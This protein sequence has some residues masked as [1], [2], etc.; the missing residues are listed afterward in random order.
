MPDTELVP[1]YVL[2]GAD[3]GNFRRLRGQ[4]CAGECVI[5]GHTVDLAR[6]IAPNLDEGERLIWEFGTGFLVTDAA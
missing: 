6:D 5:C 2:H 4:N 3:G 1:P